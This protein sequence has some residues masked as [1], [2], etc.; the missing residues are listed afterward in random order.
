MNKA[1]YIR[2]YPNKEQSEYLNRLL[3][4]CRFVYNNC[5]EYKKTRYEN[6]KLNTSDAEV[7]KHLTEI[8]NEFT[9][10]KDVHS[11][12]LQQS[13]RDLSKAYKN[14]FNSGKGYPNFKKKSN[15]QKCR[16]PNDAFIG[17]K[18][19][20]ISLIKQLKDIHYKC[21]RRDEI[22]L[23]KIKKNIC[24]ATLT[25]SKSGKYYLSILVEH[26]PIHK[27]K[28]NNSVGIDLGIKD[29]V[30]TSDGEYFENKHFH[31]KEEKRLAHLQR[32]L[33]KKVKGSHNRDKA[34][35][36]L[37]R[38]S[39]KIAN[40]RKAYIHEITTKL[41]NEN[42]V[43]CME[44][45]NTSGMLSNHKLSKSIQDVS[46]NLFK[47]IL[48]YKCEWYGR[49]LVKVDRFF[50]SSKRC[51]HC[52]YI[53]KALKLSDRQWICP[54]CGHIIE[55]DYNAA[56]NIKEE[57]LRIIGLSSPKFTLVDCP[58]M[59]ERDD[60]YLKSSDRLN[61]EKYDFIEIQ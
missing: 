48:E 55:R 47:T 22:F 46:F 60:S 33:S 9:F 8:K 16:F 61:Q 59:D 10:L 21:S 58:P 57:G 17:A 25:K 38:L 2:L 40:R 37:A 53:N 43:I 32:Q 41:V 42:Q 5:L 36:S 30:I 29:F 14:F 24:S 28:V 19:N 20:R 15:E 3:G 52:G 54:Q 1:I 4:C 13:L 31:K 26:N 12:V 49:K 51:N 6:D 35:I 39:E 27:P 56:L 11:K 34:R 44:D 7:S 23:N 50:P 18:G 45:L